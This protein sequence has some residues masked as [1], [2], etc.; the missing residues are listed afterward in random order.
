[1]PNFAFRTSPH[2]DSAATC[3]LISR[4]TALTDAAAAT[5]DPAISCAQAISHIRLRDQARYK[6]N[7]AGHDMGHRG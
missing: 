4:I 2:L 5:H 1:M 6:Q 3:R 7:T